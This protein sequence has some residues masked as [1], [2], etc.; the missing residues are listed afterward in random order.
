MPKNKFVFHFETW[1]LSVQHD[2][3]KKRKRPNRWAQTLFVHQ[4]LPC[5][6]SSLLHIVYVTLYKQK[7]NCFY[8][9]MYKCLLTGYVLIIYP[10]WL[11]W[12]V[13]LRWKCVL[14]LTMK[15]A[16]LSAVKVT[17]CFTVNLLKSTHLINCM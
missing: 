10:V 8:D 6:I 2:I 3:F 12:C 16:P 15:S 7:K 13:L 5:I 11:H 1:E 17:H 9:F 14:L 4:V